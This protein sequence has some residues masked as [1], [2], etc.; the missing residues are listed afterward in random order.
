ML[1]SAQTEKLVG[2]LILIF[3][4][5]CYIKFHSCKIPAINYIAQKLIIY[6]DNV[7]VNRLIRITSSKQ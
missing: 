6:S 3:D 4:I 1:S 7:D 5:L 2:C